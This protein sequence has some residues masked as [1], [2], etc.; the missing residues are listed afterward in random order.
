[1][2]REEERKLIVLPEQI[3]E[4]EGRIENG[5]PEGAGLGVMDLKIPDKFVFNIQERSVK[6]KQRRWYKDNVHPMLE[7]MDLDIFAKTICA[8]LIGRKRRCYTN[9]TRTVRYRKAIRRRINRA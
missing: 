1:M 2:T 4:I 9:L 7:N 6:E 8:W 5:Y 3:A